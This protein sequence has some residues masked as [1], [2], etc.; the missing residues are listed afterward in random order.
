MPDSSIQLSIILPAYNEGEAI[1][2]AIEE[3][4]RCVPQFGFDAELIVI[5][6]GSPDD[7][8]QH[9]QNAAAGVEWIRLLRNERNR[10]Q[11]YSIQRG[12]AEA[13]GRVVTHN[14]V[15]LM[16]DPAQSPMLLHEIDNGADVVVV[17]RQNRSAYG[18]I[19]KLMSRA[20]VALVHFLLRSPI[21]DHNFV[22]AYRREVIDAITIETNGVSTVT[23]EW[24]VKAH[25]MGFRLKSLKLP[26]HPRVVGESTITWRKTLHSVLQLF[27]L[28]RV[29]RRVP[30]S[31][32][33]VATNEPSASASR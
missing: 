33:D 27:R 10:G 24:I 13:R 18:V 3:F 15:D 29:I 31:T 17:E 22:Q 8:W 30:I 28:A 4:A 20:N 21:R 25:R 7:T 23:T 19:R 9:A 2:V 1:T 32:R 11:V 14:G 6:D 5:D 16:F 26:Y 12:F